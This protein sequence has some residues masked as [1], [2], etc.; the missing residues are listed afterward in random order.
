MR[1]SK[2]KD[3]LLKSL[4]R[5]EGQV[6]GIQNMLEDERYCIEVLIQVQAA[7]AALTTIGLTILE[8]HAKGCVVS[9]IQHGDEKII[10]ELLDTIKQFAR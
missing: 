10:D 2:E 9:A 3:K 5:V 6:R 7:R 4:R 1:D 8:Q